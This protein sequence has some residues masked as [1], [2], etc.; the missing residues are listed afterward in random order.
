V[1]GKASQ[2]RP[3]NIPAPHHLVAGQA[4]ARR[5]TAE[6]SLTNKRQGDSSKW[7]QPHHPQVS[8]IVLGY[9]HVPI[10]E[11]ECAMTGLMGSR[12]GAMVAPAFGGV[13]VANARLEETGVLRRTIG[14]GRTGSRPSPVC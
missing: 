5:L 6:Q 3:G 8:A 1:Q 2:H 11:I 14:A 4:A 7:Q 10:A 9:W 13:R 12:A